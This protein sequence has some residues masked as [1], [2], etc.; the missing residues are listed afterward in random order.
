MQNS[1]FF[2]MLNGRADSGVL[3]LRDAGI[4]DVQK[5]SFFIFYGFFCILLLHDTNIS[6]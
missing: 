5:E 4:L 6:M 2:F 1:L 3:E